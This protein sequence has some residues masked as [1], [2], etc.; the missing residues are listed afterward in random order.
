MNLLPSLSFGFRLVFPKSNKNSSA[1][2]SMLGAILCIAVSIVPLVCVLSVSESLVSA[3]TQRL[4]GLSSGSI[5]GLV[6]KSSPLAKDYGQFEEY[7]RSIE[8]IPDVQAVWPEVNVWAL[9]AGKNYRSGALVRGVREDI[10]KNNEAFSSMIE[11]LQGSLEDFGKNPKEC[12]VSQVIAEKLDLHLGDSF[13]LVTTSSQDGNLRPKMTGFKVGAVVSSGY[14]EIDSLWIFVPIGETISF[15]S[16]D[17]RTS[18]VL[19]DLEDPFSSNLYAV[20]QQVDKIAKGHVVVENWSEIHATRLERYTSTKFLLVLIMLLVVLIASVN[21]SSALVMLVMERKKE[22]AIIKSVGASPSFVVA[23]F[24]FAGILSCV[25]GIALGLPLGLV[26]SLNINQIINALEF[27]LNKG[28]SFRSLFTGQWNQ[29][30]I[31]LMDKAYYLS[32]IPVRIPIEQIVFLC[33][34]VILLSAIVS[35]IPS[36]KAGKEKPLDI[37]RKG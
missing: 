7:C 18:S 11:V 37:I 31:V 36:V 4:I 30:Q 3:M 10:F 12:V 33:F 8:E 9:A 16:E 32:S 27:V 14:Q 5:H 23:A 6:R 28:M 15:A 26:V 29:D 2:K 22:I 34:C 35:I 1:R 13:R 19:I 21:I 17:T 24:L 25:L 20:Q